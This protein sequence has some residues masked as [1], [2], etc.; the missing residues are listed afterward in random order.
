MVRVGSLEMDVD[1][2]DA[3][4]HAIKWF[5]FTILTLGLGAFL[6]PYALAGFCI[7]RTRIQT[8]NG[9]PSRLVC[10]LDASSRI[11]H[12]L[13]WFLLAWLTLGLAYFIY[14]YRVGKFVAEHTHVVEG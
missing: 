2:M 9:A 6:Y 5:L 10:Q 13:I 11:G 12:A 7:N 8:D 3:T 14:L 4:L 1:F